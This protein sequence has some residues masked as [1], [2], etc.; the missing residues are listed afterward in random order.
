M[1]DDNPFQSLI[2]QQGQSQAQAPTDLGAFSQL[3]PGAPAPQQ[4]TPQQPSLLQK[5][6]EAVADAYTGA[7][8]ITDGMAEGLFK[9]VGLVTGSDRMVDAA[10]S[11]IS[12]TNNDVNA[13]IQR[14]PIA[15]RIG[16]AAGYGVGYAPAVALSPAG[17]LGQ[18]L[19]QAGLQAL[20]G[21]EDTLSDKAFNSVTSGLVGAALTGAISHAPDAIRT[22]G[23]YLGSKDSV[24]ADVAA[25]IPTEAQGTI[26][27][28]VG[29]AERMGQPLTPGEASQNIPL[30]R[31]ETKIPVT[32]E[33]QQAANQVLGGRSQALKDQFQSTIHNIVSEGN[34]AAD[35]AKSAL[36]QKASVTS[37]PSE[38]EAT[39][40][41]NPAIAAGEAQAMKDPYSTIQMQ[42]PGTVGYWGSVKTALDNK[43]G[44]DVATGQSNPN[45][46]NALNTLKDNLD[47]ISPEYATARGIAQRQILQR[48]LNDSLD[49]IQLAPGQTQPTLDQMYT[50]LAGTTDARN[51]FLRA[52]QVGGGDTGK[53]QDLLDFT[54]LVRNSPI[55]KLLTKTPDV[56]EASKF[57]GDYSTQVIEK[58]QKL[59][60]GNYNKAL[61]DVTLN[62]QTNGVF[63][64]AG[65]E[66]SKLPA[67]NIA[68]G[69]IAGAPA[70]HYLLGA[71]DNVQSPLGVSKKN[72]S[73]GN[74]Y[75][76]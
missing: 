40:R 9:T 13:A 23:G 74:L 20:T 26:A 45:V 18:G 15:S 70:L 38:M 76:K 6:F 27:S 10:N 65:Q 73:L 7:K 36:Y 55:N 66:V 4:A 24:A 56:T 68:A 29:L 47:S 8:S 17:A 3:L 1:A 39:L 44:M 46:T 58:L 50:K 64:K 30:Q 22:I 21:Q 37:V 34:D 42:K 67:G 25:K 75:H 63:Q 5:G 62:P 49:N 51:Q 52:V 71:I 31:A 16:E 35:A 33:A 69:V 61:L 43:I 14:S 54:N 48:N 59:M 11:A 57:G 32:F 12:D 53:A 19:T 60:S 41:S 2:P 28:N 72:T